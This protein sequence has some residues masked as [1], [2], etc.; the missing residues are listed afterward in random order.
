MEAK[1]RLPRGV[2]WTGPG[3]GW[4]PPE[5][6]QPALGFICHKCASAIALE[7][8]RLRARKATRRGTRLALVPMCELCIHRMADAHVVMAPVWADAMKQLRQVFGQP[9]KPTKKPRRP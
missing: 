6:R 3:K 2:E 5:E 8:Q 1:K 9:Y 4:P 7:S